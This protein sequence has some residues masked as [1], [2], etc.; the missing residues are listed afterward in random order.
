MREAEREPVQLLEFAPEPKGP[1]TASV[2]FTPR[3]PA[4]RVLVGAWASYPW[5]EEL[6]VDVRGSSRRRDG[7]LH[8]FLVGYR[9]PSFAEVPVAQTLSFGSVALSIGNV[10]LTCHPVTWDTASA[11][12]YTVD[13]DRRPLEAFAIFCLASRLFDLLIPLMAAR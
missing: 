3:R 8:R 12:L 11:A 13:G 6:F 5:R 1:D 9:P 10:L 2:Q 7:T 4:A